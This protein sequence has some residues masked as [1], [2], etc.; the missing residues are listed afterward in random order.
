MKNNDPL[1][2]ITD[3]GKSILNR[4]LKVHKVYQQTDNAR[5]IKLLE[6][7][8]PMIKRLE[9]IAPVNFN[10]QQTIA[11]IIY[12]KEYVQYCRNDREAKVED[13]EAI[14]DSESRE[15]TPHEAKAY[16]LAQKHHALS[17]RDLNPK[18]EKPRIEVVIRR[19][20]ET[21]SEQLRIE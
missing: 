6:L 19:P 7:C 10:S 21:E 17:W 16:R 3:E 11:L 20:I 4:L 18:G 5:R 12:G 1:T 9:E 13:A 2:A 8:Q 15:M 14:F